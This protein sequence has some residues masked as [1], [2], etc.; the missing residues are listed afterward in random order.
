[1]SNKHYNW[2]RFW[3]PREATINLSDGGYL[4]DPDSEWGSIHNPSVLPFSSMAKFPCLVLLGEPGLGKTDTLNTEKQAIDSTV[5]D[6]SGQTCWFDLRPYGS[7]DRLVRDLFDSPTFACWVK[8]NHQLHVFLDSLDEGLLRISTL[9][10]LLSAKLKQYP[11]ERLSLRIACRT[12]DWPSSLEEELKRLWGEGGMGVY[13]LAPLRRADVVEAVKANELDPDALLREIDRMEAVPLAIKPVTLGFLLSTYRK[14]GRFPRTQSA[15]YLDGCRLLCEETN[16]SRRDSGLMRKCGAEELVAVAARIAAVTVFAN[17]YAVW[18]GVDSGDVPPEDVCIR[19]LCGGS[20]DV[21][22]R[23]CNVD[24]AVIRETLSTGLFSSRGSGRLGWAHQSYAEFLAV[25]YLV[26][27]QLSIPQMMSL[28]VHSGDTHGKLVPQLQETAAWLAGMVPDIFREIMKVDPQVLLRGDVATADVQDR[29]GLVESLLRLYDKEQLLDR[30][31]DARGRYHK[32]AHPGL[33]G[34]LRPYIR[35][36]TKGIIVRRVA[37]DM[38]EA[39][40]LK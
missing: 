30:D 5:A 34:Q 13:E 12:A 21:N 28:I 7:E 1:M 39:C 29:A 17:K 27:R 26:Q 36:R 22:G 32:L 6:E 9:A 33:A 37:G 4:Y 2:K 19:E 15:L 14:T 11:V 38:A 10:A 40:E 3:S 23:H 24:E 16:K 20:E 31:L 25:C 8:G 18:A 35:D